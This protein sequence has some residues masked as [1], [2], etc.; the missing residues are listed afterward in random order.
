MGMSALLIRGPAPLMH[1]AHS[2]AP[3]VILDWG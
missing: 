2:F 3:S 1:F